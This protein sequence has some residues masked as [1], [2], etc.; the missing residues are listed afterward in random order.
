[1]IENLLGKAFYNAYFHYIVGVGILILGI[2]VANII[3]VIL[4]DLLT[5]GG[6]NSEDKAKILK[7]VSKIH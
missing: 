4:R 2:I 5:H 1:M 7:L 6:A 3:V